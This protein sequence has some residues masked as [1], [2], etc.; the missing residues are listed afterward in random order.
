M[1]VTGF[2]V[3]VVGAVASRREIA[4]ARGPEKILAL[5]DVSFAVPL[6]IFGALHLFGPQLVTALIP[7]YMPWPSF[8]AYAVGAALVAASLSIATGIATR[9]SALLFGV[10]M[11]LFVAM[12]HLPGALRNPHDRIIWTIV[13]R[14]SSFG[15]AGWILAATAAGWHLPGR[16]VVLNVG[17]ALVTLA[18]IV[19]G[20]EHFLFPTGLPGVPL[21]KQM[22]EWIP[23][24]QLIDYVTGA[25]LLAAAGSV[26]LRKNTR[27]MTTY[28]GGWLLLLVVVIYIP[29]M[30][31]AFAEPGQGG[32]IVGLNYFADTLLFAGCVLALA[33][34]S[35]R[36]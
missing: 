28:A 1:F 22:V 13:V 18:L 16:S 4:R 32:K 8:W 33:K 10:M 36:S 34:S 14:E 35:E 24:R 15:G 31:S 11:F 9:W 3:L 25:V 6:A 29:V 7:K 20:V 2:A 5:T 26:L 23:A 27:M 30:I 12:I 21:Q 19:F 17:R